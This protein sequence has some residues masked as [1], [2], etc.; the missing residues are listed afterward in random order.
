M[1]LI[2]ELQSVSTTCILAGTPQSG[3]LPCITGLLITVQTAGRD[4]TL[5]G[6]TGKLMLEGVS[7]FPG[8][9]YPTK[10][11]IERP[12][13]R[14]TSDPLQWHRTTFLNSK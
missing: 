4:A 9:G 7:H 14:R 13:L 6:S 11:A 1:V 10:I 12:N 2:V 3:G 5:A 8:T